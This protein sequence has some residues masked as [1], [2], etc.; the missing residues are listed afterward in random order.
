M[1]CNQWRS[2]WLTFPHPKSQQRSL[3]NSKEFVTNQFNREQ[4]SRTV[5]ICANVFR[6]HLWLCIPWRY[7]DRASS[8]HFP[9]RVNHRRDRC[10]H[11][12]IIRQCHILAPTHLN[13]CW[14]WHGN[15]E[16]N[17][18]IFSVAQHHQV[19][20]I[21]INVSFGNDSKCMLDLFI[22]MKIIV[23]LLRIT[24]TWLLWKMSPETGFHC[25][26]EDCILFRLESAISRTEKA[27]RDQPSQIL[28][29]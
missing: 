16:Y 6:F 15:S 19:V 7:K 10:H 26:P 21:V 24:N 4:P 29:S 2:E 27:P 20:W 11:R 9:H 18:L 8:N 5:W 14:V 28:K 25:A 23:R 17:V 13:D 1:W 3:C 12:E 22:A